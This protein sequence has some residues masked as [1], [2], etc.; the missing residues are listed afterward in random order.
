M[1][2]KNGMKGK[3]FNLVM[4]MN[5]MIGGQFEEGLESINAV[6]TQKNKKTAAP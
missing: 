5:N 4:N 2:G 6:V 3:A 1:K